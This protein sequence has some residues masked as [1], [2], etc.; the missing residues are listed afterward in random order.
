MTR[1]SLVLCAVV[2]AGGIAAAQVDEGL[3]ASATELRP[4]ASEPVGDVVRLLNGGEVVGQ[5][6]RRGAREISIEVSADI[7]LKVP[8]KLV[9]TIEYDDYDPTRSAPRTPRSG[10][11]PR[12]DLIPGMKC[13]AELFEK[14]NKDI[15]DPP[16][17]YAL[18]DV[19]VILDD[20]AK[21]ADVTIV[22]A[23]PVKALSRDQRQWAIEPP[24]KATL[25]LL[26]E[27]DLQRKLEQ[28]RVIYQQN[29]ILV[30]TKK[31]ARALEAS[32]G[33]PDGP[34]E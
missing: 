2:G 16:L 20:L 33:S 3:D 12:R 26:L 5:V 22:I 24:P 8:R 17:E 13:S 4:V 21:R 11:A 18:K 1:T 14:L 27:D 19:V 32:Q 15:S 6:V 7:I 30:T 10:D 31:A 25:W 34:A 23:D 29:K 9:D 28:I